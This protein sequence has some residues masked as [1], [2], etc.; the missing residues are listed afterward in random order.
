MSPLSLPAPHITLPAG[1]AMRALVDGRKL[2]VHTLSAAPVAVSARSCDVPA[3]AHMTGPAGSSI[4][5]R[6]WLPA[7]SQA[8]ATV[9][10]APTLSLTAYTAS[11]LFT[12]FTP[13]GTVLVPEGAGVPSRLAYMHK[14]I[15]GAVTP[16]PTVAVVAA[17]VTNTH[18]GARHSAM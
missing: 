4:P 2:H 16:G 10:R 7:S 6:C 15:A 1:L 9:R 13:R 14:L 5:H 3:H 17:A 11:A 12:S 18:C 8:V